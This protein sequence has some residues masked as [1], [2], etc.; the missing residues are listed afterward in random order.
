LFVSFR[1]NDIRDLVP[2]RAPVRIDAA[3]VD[4]VAPAFLTRAL[5]ASYRRAG[6]TLTERW[7]PTHHSGVMHARH[8]PT[9]AVGWIAERFAAR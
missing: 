9:E 3:R 4:E 1:D 5:F 8:A 2:D 7:W 6:V